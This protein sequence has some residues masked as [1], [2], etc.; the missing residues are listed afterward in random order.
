MKVF[1]FKFYTLFYFLYLLSW[2]QKQGDVLIN[3]YQCN[4]LTDQKNIKCISFWPSDLSMDLCFKHQCKRLRT[5]DFTS[6]L[7]FKVTSELS[8][9]LCGF[10]QHEYSKQE[11]RSVSNSF[12][13]YCQQ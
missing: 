11:T 4:A 9:A 10:F 3:T 5:P 8:L 13:L 1:L 2:K 6:K 12:V 7:H